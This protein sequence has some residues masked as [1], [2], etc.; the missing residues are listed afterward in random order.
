M[1]LSDHER[2]VLAEMEAALEKDDP[3]LHS[4]LNTLPKG[5]KGLTLGVCAFLLGMSVLLGGLIAKSVF[6][7]VLGFVISLVGSIVLINALPK[8]ESARASKGTGKGSGKSWSE[9]MQERWEQRDK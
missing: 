3:K 9:K 6:V 4:T 8:G 5:G 7:G 2:Q 1:P